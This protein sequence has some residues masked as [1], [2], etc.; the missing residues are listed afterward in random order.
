MAIR[1]WPGYVTLSDG[2]TTGELALSALELVA[3]TTQL[4][5]VLL[6]V[7][8][9][10]TAVRRPRPATVDAAL[11]FGVFAA[12]IV[13]SRIATLLGASQAPWV[14]DL[15]VILLMA[16]SYL[17]LRLANDFVAVPRT[18]LRIAELGL[19]AIA[20]AAILITD[21]TL[22]VP[23]LAALVGYFATVTIGAAV[24]FVRASMRAQGISRRRLRAIAWGSY[25]PGGS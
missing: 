4:I 8:S 23:L 14:A 5:F 22:P 21:T 1:A 6:A 18:L 7:A 9:I 15:L 20:V 17:L 11:F 24:V 13:E 3:W 25:L 12:I 16:V 10:V 2:G 19:A